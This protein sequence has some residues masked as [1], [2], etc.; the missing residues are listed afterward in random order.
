MFVNTA[1]NCHTHMARYKNEYESTVHL[2]CVASDFLLNLAGLKDALPFLK[3]R[4]GRQYVNVKMNI[5]E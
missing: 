2:L 3:N 1:V 4:N 5:T